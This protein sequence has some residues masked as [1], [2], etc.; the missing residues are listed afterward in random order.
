MNRAPRDLPPFRTLI[1]H[2]QDVPRLLK[3]LFKKDGIEIT[4]YLAKVMRLHMENPPQGCGL[5]S[6]MPVALVIGTTFGVAAAG[7]ALGQ[8]ARPNISDCVLLDGDR[9]R[10]ACYDR[11]SGRTTVP[12]KLPEGTAVTVPP[13]PP[14]TESAAPLAA[15]SGPDSIID[16][17]WRFNPDSPRYTIGLYR[18]NYLQIA[19]YSDRPNN[20][21][22]EVLFEALDTPDTEL[23][24]IEAEFQLSFKARLWATEQRRFGVWLAYTQQSQWQVYNDDTSRPFRETN[25]EPELLLSFGP[26]VKLGGFH[27]RLFNLGYN[28]QSNGR[29][30]PIS[31]SWDRL[32]AEFG[33]ERDDFALL[34]RPWY[35]LDDG[36]DDNPDITDFYGHGDITAIYKWRGNSISLMGRGNVDTGKGAVELSWTTQP[37]LGPLRGYVQAFAGYGESLI[38]Y[39]WYQNSIGIGI[40]LNDLLDRP[41]QDQ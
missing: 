5:A 1:E 3:N 7:Q 9:E 20:E 39:N 11:A 38:D 2:G 37:L 25:Y 26:D 21:P 13:A 34:I 32:I 10:L 27:W 12:K 16:A 19:R 18:S 41:R 14:Q 17:A 40:A 28:H 8:E 4:Q 22:F 29:A 35:V 6:L 30:D 31:R 24:S 33:I 15:T 36:G 23:D